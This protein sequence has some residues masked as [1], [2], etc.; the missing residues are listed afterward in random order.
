METQAKEGIGIPLS[1]ST[2]VLM[3]LEDDNTV[4]QLMVNEFQEM[5]FQVWSIFIA[6]SIF[7]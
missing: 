3:L 7:L 4:Y 1:Q 2:T 6:L 5:D